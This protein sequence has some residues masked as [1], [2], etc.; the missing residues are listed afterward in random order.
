[1]L[2]REAGAIAAA[3]AG[4]RTAAR[5]LRDAFLAIAKDPI[6]IPG[7]HHHCD[8]WCDYCPVTNRCLT[9]RCA[10][11]FR[12]RHG[13][14]AGEPLFESMDE[15]VGFTRDVAAAEGMSTAALDALLGGPP[16]RALVQT[17]DPLA[18]E[19]FDYAA[20]VEIFMG[21]ALVTLMNAPPTPAAPTPAEIVVYDHLRIYMR[22][23]RA[24]VAREAPSDG[25][26]LPDDEAPGS[27]KVA[28]T[29]IARSRTALE[30]MRGTAGDRI[31]PLLAALEQLEH[32]I[33]ERFP[34]ARA[35]VRLGLDEPVA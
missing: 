1:M 17:D 35:F 34:D 15:A 21:P 10:A 11:E 18:K 7:V 25:L 23:F 30:A 33:D 19:A 9:F 20:A 16:R 13:R 12:K 6:V 24:L 4:A 31:D 8:E 29:M 14:A 26:A 32:G 27:A 22:V 2:N 3:G 28:L 5:R